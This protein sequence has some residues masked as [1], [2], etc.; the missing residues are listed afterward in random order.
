MSSNDR[1]SPPPQA[2]MSRRRGSVTQATLSTLF[3]RSSTSGPSGTAAFPGPITTAALG[4]QRRRLSLSASAGVGLSGTSPNSAFLR[5]AS[6]STNASEVIDENAVEDEEVPSRS[7]FKR[8]MSF[9]AGTSAA[10]MRSRGVPASPCTNGTHKDPKIPDN[11]PA[12]PFGAEARRRGSV[13]GMPSGSR[14]PVQDKNHRLSV[15]T[16]N[17]PASRRKPPMS[18][19]MSPARADQGF[20]WSDQLRSRAESLTMASRP[21]WAPSSSP[22]R[23]VAPAAHERAKSM[24]EMP[25]PPAQASSMRPPRESRKPDAFQERILKGDFYMD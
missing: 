2:D 6:L 24:A 20:N 12:N 5:R 23:G 18:N 11:A 22:P 16:G 14:P 13:A 1:N 15:Q 4:D 17:V 8:R 9:S 25:A 10:S 7:P 21:N 3:Q 19:M